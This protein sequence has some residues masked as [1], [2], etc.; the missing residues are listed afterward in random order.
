MNIWI[1]NVRKIMG[2]CPQKDCTI[3]QTDI[4][5]YEHNNDFLVTNKAHRDKGTDIIID[6]HK[7]FFKIVSLSA[8]GFLAFIIAS[9]IFPV[10]NSS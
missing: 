2:W 9:L 8:I 10:L 6:Y 1:E 4:D 3:A 7:D 5:K